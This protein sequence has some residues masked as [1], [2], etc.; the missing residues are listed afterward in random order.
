[1]SKVADSSETEGGFDAIENEPESIKANAALLEEGK[2]PSKHGPIHTQEE[3]QRFRA[4][5]TSHPLFPSLLKQFR[6]N[7]ELLEELDPTAK[8]EVE[9]KS[10]NPLLLPHL[11]IS[12]GDFPELDEFCINYIA[13]LKAQREAVAKKCREPEAE[14]PLMKPQPKRPKVETGGQDVHDASIE[15]ASPPLRLA[16]ENPMLEAALSS[17]RKNGGHRVCQVLAQGSLLYL[18]LDGMPSTSLKDHTQNMTERPF[19][20][21]STQHY[22]MHDAQ[23]FAPSNRSQL[24]QNTRNTAHQTKTGQHV[25]P[26]G[27]VQKI[28]NFLSENAQH[29]RRAQEGYCKVLPNGGVGGPRSNTT[30]REHDMGRKNG[31]GIPGLNIT[32]HQEEMVSAS[33]F[34]IADAIRAAVAGD[35]G[36]KAARRGKT[37]E[38]LSPNALQIL[39][40][41]FTEHLDNPYPC[42]TE[43][44]ALATQCKIS[45]S[46]VSNWFGNK[47]MR[48]K[49]KAMDNDKDKGEKNYLQWPPATQGR[50]AQYPMNIRA[51]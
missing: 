28:S 38:K 26:N 11:N 15:D 36:V 35:G 9:G 29:N 2:D 10:S 6:K 51:S 31:T 13:R 25:P 27:P 39:E 12:F 44:Q 45:V 33:S 5:L 20:D 19:L 14:V 42:E 24:V 1:M 8:K 37:R 3:L 4:V 30:L 18:N 34:S 46:Q 17:L 40:N 16:S 32:E 49:R 48:F 21:K 22:S 47:R 7:A 23:Q 43:K 50:V 41:W